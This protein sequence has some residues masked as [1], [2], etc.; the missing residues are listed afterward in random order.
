M[1]FDLDLTEK[2]TGYQRWMLNSVRPWMGT[3]VLEF[4]AGTGNMSRWLSET[5]YLA[6]LEPELNLRKQLQKGVRT[7]FSKKTH[8]EISS[9]ALPKGSL[10]SFETKRLDTVISFNVLEHIK[11]D[12]ETV[13][14]MADLL[15]KSK[16]PCT[17]RLISVVPAH[18]F[19]YSKM[20][21][22]VG[23]YR[24]YTKTRLNAIAAKIAP[25]ASHHLASFNF[26]G[27][28]GWTLK[29]KILGSDRIGEVS[30]E[31]FEKLLPLIKFTDF[32]AHRILRLPLGLSFISVLEWPAR[33]L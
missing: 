2:A 24:R 23:H 27:L 12:F 29:G 26:A 19:A 4:G 31:S 5:E 20:D 15:R 3:R 9:L 13:K 22:W 18:S 7:W 21:T 16:T 6:L 25:E 8:V 17:R 33:K 30:I 14:K 10:K 11:D 28:L 32:V 1:L